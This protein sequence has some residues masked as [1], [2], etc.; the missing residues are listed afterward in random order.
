MY[1]NKQKIPST[2]IKLN[3]SYAGETIEQKINRITNNKEPIKD[4]APLIYT[5]RKNGVQPQYDIRTDRFE[6]AVEAMDKVSKAEFAKREHRLGERAKANMEK[7]KSNEKV[8]TTGE[9]PKE[10]GGQSTE[11]TK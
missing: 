7:E 10:T 2:S 11:A 6:V 9:T 8:T 3:D 5:D 1:K 4:G